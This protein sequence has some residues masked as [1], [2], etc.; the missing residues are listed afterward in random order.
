[1]INITQIQVFVSCPS[2]VNAEKRLVEEVC[3][4]INKNL[5]QIGC[6]IQLTVREWSE[7][8]GQVGVQPQDSINSTFRDYDI[9]LGILWMRFG[10]PTKNI[11][12]T[13]GKPFLSGTEEEFEIAYERWLLD[14]SVRINFFFKD[15][16]AIKNISEHEQYGKVLGFK[17][18]IKGIG[19]S[20]SFV[21]ENNFKDQIY[22][23][24]SQIGFKMCLEKKTEIKN[25][26]VNPEFKTPASE[27]AKEKLKLIIDNSLKNIE[28]ISHYIPRSVKSVRDDNQIAKQIFRDLEYETLADIMMHSNRI[29]IL[30]NAGTGKSVEL[31]QLAIKFSDVNT[32]YIPIYKR[33]NTYVDDDIENY[34]PLGWRE[35]NP[36]IVLLLFDGLDEVQPKYF[37]TAIRKILNFSDRFPDLKI[38]ISC[39]TNFYELPTDSFSGTLAGFNCYYLNDLSIEEIKKYVTLNFEVDGEVFIQNAFKEKYLDI[40]SKPFFLNILV[41]HFKQFG[42]LNSKRSEIIKGF[43]LSR[44]NF[45]QI[46]FKTTVEKEKTKAEIIALLQRVSL[47]M[48]MLGRNFITTNELI[49]VVLTDDNFDSLKYFSAFNKKNDIEETWS[50]EH[51]NIQEYLAA[52]ILSGSSIVSIKQIISFPPFFKKIKPSWVN[53]LSFLISIGDENEVNTLIDWLVA[54]EPEIVIKFEK[55]RIDKNL[56]ISLFKEVFQS[57]KSKGIWLRSNKFTDTELADFSQS[58]E[59]IEYLLNEMTD[60]SNSRVII[61]NAIGIIEHINFSIFSPLYLEKLKSIFFDLLEKESSDSGFVYSIF[62]AMAV[63][64]LNNKELLD[65]VLAIFGKR[66]NQY[67]RAGLYKLIGESSYVN[68]Y[69]DVF[70]D[71]IELSDDDSGNEDR[72]DVNLADEGWLL[73]EAL[74]QANSPNAIK[75]ILTFFNDPADRR[76]FSFYEKKEVF[77]AVVKNATKLFLTTPSIYDYIFG[78]FITSGKMYDFDYAIPLVSFFEQTKTKER[79]FMD[80]WGNEDISSYEKGTL[81][82][83]LSDTSIVDFFVNEFVNRNFTNEDV[84]TFHKDIMWYARPSEV[85]TNLATH[86]EQEIKEKTGIEI[87]KQQV[88]DHEAI[89]RKKVQE[90]FDL[91]FDTKKLLSEINRVFLEVESGELS[92]DNL[93]EVRRKN[94]QYLDDYFPAIVLSILRDFTRNQSIVKFETVSNWINSQRFEFYQINEI[95]DNLKNN[96]SIQISEMQYEFINNWSHNAASRLDW[97]SIVKK[98]GVTDD[99]FTISKD[100]QILWHFVDKLNIPLNQEQLLGFTLFGDFRNS[101]NE[102]SHEIIDRLEDFVDIVELQNKVKSNLKLGIG[103]SWIWKSNALYAITNNLVEV[104]PLI[105]ENLKD[106]SKSEYQRRDVLTIYFKKTQNITSLKDILSVIKADSLES[107]IIELLLPHL[108]EKEFLINYLKQKLNSTNISIAAKLKAAKYL[109]DLNDIDGLSFYTDYLVNKNDPSFDSH[110]LNFLSKLTSTKAIPDLFKLLY[111]VR[112]PEFQAEKFNFLESAVLSGFYSIGL[113]SEE[114][115]LKVKSELNSFI[116]RYQNELP[117]LNF[118]QLTIDRIEDQFYMNKSKSYSIE[119]AITQIKAASF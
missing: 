82:S 116:S 107:T 73:K 93:W 12:P 59:V 109:T 6:S 4:R 113:F 37:N 89:N 7:V 11:N 115:L 3:E 119:E 104:F 71:G 105:V 103:V 19:M 38:I 91:L 35:I 62:R 46:H 110:Q 1:M 106:E 39:R 72:E 77:A 26:L 81:V 36:E 87:E 17:D 64:K 20:N 32:P 83:L 51:N 24:L 67:I 108:D 33:F 111:M 52:S 74:I 42:N 84:F 94:G 5:L 98:N 28:Q 86:L 92:Y 79:A 49:K 8:F 68:E 45:D 69:I 97:Q 114:N 54:T 41:S 18:R 96:Q 99:S 112:K 2:D 21:D 88:I 53:T 90:N 75:K 61:L 80:V 56:R 57:Y 43:I 9:Y 22:D 118:L 55:D 60:T 15:P 100:A 34:L 95:S 29:V 66:R 50:F 76:H 13:T 48:E 14:Q 27:V 63:L 25:E 101:I 78:V 10:T 85:R 65:K 70:L 30:G 44:I 58:E 40:V 117:N 31:Q 102:P 23:L 16:V 47:A